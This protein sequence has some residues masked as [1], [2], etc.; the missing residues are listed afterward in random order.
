MKNKYNITVAIPTYNSSIY[1]KECLVGFKNSKYINEILIGDDCSDKEDFSNVQTIVE[2][3]KNILNCEIKLLRNSKNIGAYANKYSLV[4]TAKND[5][6]YQIDSDN[7]PIKNIDRIIKNVLDED[8][9][10]EYIYY[11][12]KLIQ[13]RKYKKIAQLFSS[14]RKK[15]RVIF[16]NK[17]LIFDMSKTKEAVVEN[18]SYENR[19]KS[20]NDIENFPE[21]NSDYTREKHI[22][23]VLNCGNFIVNKSIFKKRMKKGLNYERELLSMDALAFSYL[24]LKN[25]GSIKLMEG[26]THYHRKRYDS[27]SF[28]ERESSVKSREYFTNKILESSL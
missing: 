15:Y 10:N 22:F 24:W 28:I 26:L 8:S 4:A 2:D 27:V 14:F 23:W 11:P 7:V 19:K 17:S 3:V 6:V 18:V 20:S 5:W 12:T 16:S 21:L 13:F 25:G 1:L 9:E